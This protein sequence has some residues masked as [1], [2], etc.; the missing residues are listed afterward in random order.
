MGE[1]FYRRGELGQAIEYLQNALVHF[2]RPRLPVSPGRVELHILNEIAVL[3]GY[4]VFRHSS[5]GKSRG[6]GD[7]VVREV[8]RTYDFLGDIYVLQSPM[9]L[10]S[11]IL[12]CLNHSF[13]TRYAPG[14]AEQYAPLSLVVHSLSLPRLTKFFLERSLALSEKIQHPVA[15]PRAY[16][17]SCMIACDTGQ[18][19][20]AVDHA[21]KA[22]EVSRRVEYTALHLWA[23]ALAY[24]QWAHVRRGEFDQADRLVHELIRVGE[25]GND[26]YV[27]S[28]G[29]LCLLHSAEKRGNLEH[30]IAIGKRLIE[31]FE[32]MPAHEFR[33]VT[34]YHLHKFYLRLG[35]TERSLQTLTE[36]DEY[37]IR[38]NVKIVSYMVISGYPEV[39]LTLAEEA[40]G[41]KKTDFLRKAKG[42]LKRS[43][44]YAEVRASILP[45]MTR[46]QG[47][48]DW[49]TGRPSSARK[50]WHRSLATAEKMG[51]R[52]DLG[53]TH[54]E[55][56]R[57]L[58]G[59][60]HL[61]KAEAI[62]AEIG[63]EFDLAE[64]R[65]YLYPLA[66]GKE[67]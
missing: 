24:A 55:M 67:A 33:T 40:T 63:A 61:Q 25:E 53:M 60:E 50:Y 17:V 23:G 4:L 36:T 26:R 27:H 49:L 45:E 8:V 7:R 22:A 35:E 44:R 11:T 14:I 12:T 21:Y 20:R 56:G 47:T 48:Y 59:R 66:E 52:Y 28:F 19:Q 37:R 29:L 57:R 18:L 58:N 64:T 13:A 41:I 39:Y 62:F 51:M 1:A 34:G 10:L 38:H 43:L 5:I 31:I 16:V 3:I 32:S 6:S 46:L 65:K 30:S 15:L 2:G 54:L 9:P 42:A